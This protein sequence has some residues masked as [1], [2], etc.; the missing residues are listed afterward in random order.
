MKRSVTVLVIIIL[1]IS[2]L[3]IIGPSDDAEAGVFAPKV[4]YVDDDGISTYTHPNAAFADA[5]PEDIIFIAPGNYHIVSMFGKS[6]LKIYGN[7]SQGEVRFTG[8]VEFFPFYAYQS[9]N[10]SISGITMEGQGIA[11]ELIEC[12]DITMTFM[13][14]KT[15]GSS[16]H[17]V[18]IRDSTHVTIFLSSVTSAVNNEFA[19]MLDN[20]DNFMAAA[21]SVAMS[22]TNSGVLEAVNSDNLYLEIESGTYTGDILDLQNSSVVTSKTE[23]PDDKV[24][25][26]GTSNIYV[27]FG[28]NII[29]RE[30]DNLTPLK[31]V[32][33]NITKDGIPIFKTPHFGGLMD[34]SN[35]SGM[36]PIL[37]SLTEKEFSGSNTPAY[38]NNS[39]EFYHNGL[40]VPGEVA[41]NE[42]DSGTTDDLIV[43]F[44]DMRKPKVAEN[45][46]AKTIDH[47]TI[48]IHFDAS[49]STDVDHYEIYQREM[50][51]WDIILET[52][53]IGDHDIDGLIPATEHEFAVVAVDDA[54]LNS[55]WV[56]VTNTT[57]DPVEGRLNGTIL[58]SGGPLNGTPVDNAT[59]TAVYS[60]TNETW[61]GN[62]TSEGY[63]D[64]G[65]IL[66]QDYLNVT[67]IHP[68]SVEEGGNVSGYLDTRSTIQFRQAT[69]VEIHMPYYEYIP[70]TNGTIWGRITYNGGPMGGM[71][72]TNA[73]VYLFN[74]T[75]ATVDIFRVNETGMYRFE[76]IPFGEDYLLAA[77]PV[78]EVLEDG[79][80]SGYIRREVS[81]DFFSDHELDV[82][83]EY[84]TYIPPTEGD[85]IG[86][87]MFKNGPK[88]GGYAPGVKVEL[89]NGSG[90]LIDS[91]TTN[92]TGQYHFE[93]IASGR[94]YYL[95]FTPDDDD[96]GIVFERGGYLV[97][98]GSPF[99]HLEGGSEYDASL[100][101]HQ[102]IVEH[103]SVTIVDDGGFPIRDAVVVATV[104]GK[105]YTAVTDENGMAVFD[106]L[107]GT[108]FPDGTTFEATKDGYEDLNWSYGDDIPAMKEEGDDNMILL[109][110]ILAVALIMI[111]L[112]VI[113]FLLLRKGGAA[114]LSEE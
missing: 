108:D 17:T 111:L 99:D 37:P 18:G 103:P 26:D 52:D 67:V 81:F 105:L 6:G 23:V 106:D 28:R 109:F 70:A 42:V 43:L 89:F 3:F 68:D 36:F 93:D 73:T 53:T 40:D 94:G 112:S 48:R 45:V 33:L 31:G 50:S 14:F 65:I 102:H 34:V 92:D 27:Y 7:A 56:H 88:D 15:M 16:F 63:F 32:E 22:G 55:S 71:N 110:M 1:S 77:I 107:N 54:E 25:V 61:E 66:F 10:I 35:E 46:S 20:A 86:R 11:A 41:L 96:L 74:E 72:A 83:L 19:F 101:Y 62:T 38:I 24:S 98:T 90:V 60:V 114:D 39:M 95:R 59:V 80:R 69:E 47:D 5:N 91:T 76:E 75:Q 58:Y 82:D 4:L 44:P 79:N 84:Y 57:G 30:E 97:L 104:D 100:N 85:I 78:D 12:V 13:K 29:V 87:V 2:G 64:L 9:T 51:G 8:S 49:N 21:V 113:A